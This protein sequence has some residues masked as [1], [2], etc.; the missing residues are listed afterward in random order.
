[1]ARA[2]D[3]VRA[4]LETDAD[5]PLDTNVGHYVDAVAADRASGKITY[6][7]ALTCNRFYHRQQKYKSGGPKEVRRN[8]RTKTWKTR[9]GEFRIPVKYGMYECFYID[10][11]NADQWSTIPNFDQ[12]K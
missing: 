6:D 8:G 5:D 2:N 12:L 10:N 4:L 3:I 7:Q 9:P 1:M 11:R